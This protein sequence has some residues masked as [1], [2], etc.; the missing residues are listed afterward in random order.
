MALCPRS[1]GQGRLSYLGGGRRST[2]AHSID[3]SAQND[4]FWSPR[5]SLSR[6]GKRRGLT[7]NYPT[8]TGCIRPSCHTVNSFEVH[9]HRSQGEDMARVGG[10]VMAALWD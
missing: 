2:P 7:P 10:S 4:R 6:G 3:S 5:D 1:T 9:A 8:D